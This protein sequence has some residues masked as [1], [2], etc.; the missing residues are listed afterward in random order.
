MKPLNLNDEKIRI[1]LAKSIAYDMLAT[2][3]K[4]SETRY[5]DYYQ[6]AQVELNR[7]IK[8][9]DNQTPIYKA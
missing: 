1:M 7:M 4:I 3:K 9:A 2:D 6:K 5:I 8:G